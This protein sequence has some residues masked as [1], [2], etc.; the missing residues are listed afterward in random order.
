M[1]SRTAV[2]TVAA[3]GMV[4]ATTSEHYIMDPGELAEV[5][6]RPQLGVPPIHTV[7]PVDLFGRPAA[8]VATCLMRWSRIAR[9]HTAR[10]ANAVAQVCEALRRA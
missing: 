10:W 4:G 3:L 7:T 6:D 1:A 2:A 5:L 9:R 8:Q